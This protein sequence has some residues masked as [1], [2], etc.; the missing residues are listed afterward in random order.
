[1]RSE[2]HVLSEAL[3][4]K[5][6]ILRPGIICDT[7][8]NGILSRLDQ[9]LLAFPPIQ[10]MRVLWGLPSKTGR[11]PVAKFSNGTISFRD[12]NNLVVEGSSQ[13]FMEDADRGFRFNLEIANLTASKLELV[14]RALL[15]CALGC[16]YFD[17]G[18]RKLVGSEWDDV[19]SAVRDGG[20]R[21]YVM[22]PSR[23]T[24]GGPVELRYWTGD[25]A[26][27]GYR[28][29]VRLEVRGMLCL[30][31]LGHHMPSAEIIGVGHVLSFPEPRRTPKIRLTANGT[32]GHKQQL[33]RDDPAVIAA[34]GHP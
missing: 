20:H 7:C 29:A 14:S 10:F 13:R 28:L 9:A 19:R 5:S 26:H 34:I 2:E 22:V 25:P 24:M 12:G 33:A 18:Y 21:G 4:N 15:K 8:N 17:H 31:V 11:N 23:M 6:L 16:A 27:D 3:G 1:M 32:F 30:T